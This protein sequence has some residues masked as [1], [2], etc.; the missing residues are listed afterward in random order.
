MNAFVCSCLEPVGSKVVLLRV[1]SACINKS[2]EPA[3][4]VVNSLDEG[5]PSVCIPCKSREELIID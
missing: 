2:E 4:L 1:L 3:I 5:D